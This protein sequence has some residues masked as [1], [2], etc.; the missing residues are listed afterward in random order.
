[1]GGGAAGPG[2]G[3]KGVGGRGG[4]AGGYRKHHTIQFSDSL[5]WIRGRHVIKFGTDQRWN[6]LNFVNRLNPSGTFSFSASLTNN[7]QVPAGSG[8][9][10]ASFLLGFVSGGSL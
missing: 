10:F 1:M 2:G 4:F 6:R 3:G 5:T 9:G 7:P 8:F